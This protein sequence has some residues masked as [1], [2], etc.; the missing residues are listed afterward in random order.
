MSI[1]PPVAPDVPDAKRR[2]SHWLLA[3]L[4]VE[5]VALILLSWF[6]WARLPCSHTCAPTGGRSPRVSNDASQQACVPGNG[7]PQ[8]FYNAGIQ[9]A[10]CDGSVRF[11]T[12][13]MSAGTWS[14]ALTYGGGEVMAAD[15]NE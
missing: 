2:I 10:L 12:T 4:V 9:V 11:C 1:I 14:A 5:L 3:S 6:F 8:S 7:A 13:G 15:W